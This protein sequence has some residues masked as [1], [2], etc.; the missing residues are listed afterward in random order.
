VVFGVVPIVIGTL[1]GT[2]I[3]KKIELY[4]SK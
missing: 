4:A 3:V 1:I 2:P